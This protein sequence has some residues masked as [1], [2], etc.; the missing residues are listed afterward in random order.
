MR[1]ALPFQSQ[2][3]INLKSYGFIG[4]P[5]L[6]V[7]QVNVG[8]MT[9]EHRVGLGPATTAAFMGCGAFLN[10]DKALRMAPR[11]AMLVMRTVGG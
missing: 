7:P 1:A 3:H 2:D 6:V 11:E 10:E 9:G 5:I 4:F 8:V